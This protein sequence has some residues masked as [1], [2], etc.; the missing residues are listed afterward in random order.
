LPSDR[1]QFFQQL[2]KDATSDEEKIRRIYHYLQSNFRYVSIQL[3]IGGLKPFPATFTDQKK[4]GDC[5]ALSNYMKAALKAVGIKSYVA[6]INA[7]HNSIPVD[8]NFPANDFNHVILCVPQTKDSIWLECTS[9][10]A[11]F[12]KLGTF[13][14]NRNALLIT[15]EGGVLVPT[16]KS[17]A[18]ENTL[19]TH[20]IVTMDDDLSGVAEVSFFPTGAFNEMITDVLKNSKDDQKEFI[21]FYMGYKQPDDFVFEKAEAAE[22]RAKLRMGI[23]KL[24]EFTAGDKYFFSARIN[25]YSPGKLPSAENRKMDFYFYY[26][27]EERDTTVLKLPHNFKPDVLPNEKTLTTAYTYYQS[28]SWFNEKE[29]A[30]Y[31]STT[32]V[33]KNHKVPAADYASVKDFFD[34]VTKDEAQRIVM[35]KTGDRVEEK[36]AF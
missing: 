23:R 24:P 18:S 11:E 6:I 28:K 26:P 1:Q 15:E 19:T 21:V 31:T 12:G 7:E 33:L 22:H 25:K 3:G 36:K 35:K 10:T 27:F 17:H 32:L 16:P 13:T 2:V 29:N 4:Y 20:T 9:S 30:L 14:E 5:K 8:P 34:E